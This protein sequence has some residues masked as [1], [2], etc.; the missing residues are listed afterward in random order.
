V[1]LDVARLLGDSLKPART[2]IFVAFDG[3]EWGL[4]GSRRY[5]ATMRHWP[6]A[7]AH[8]MVNL[9]TVGRLGDQRLLVLGSGTATEWPHIARGVGF[10]TG[11]DSTC[12]ADDPGGSDQVVF[13][14]HGVPAVQL[15]TGPHEDYHRSTDTADKLDY[16]GLVKVATWLRETIVYLAGRRES[17]T[18]TLATRGPGGE[19]L[20]ERP[21]TGRRVSLGTMPD[22]AFAGPGVKVASVI[23]GSPAEQA[24]VQANDVIIAVD[25]AALT[26]LKA[27]GAALRGKS[28]GDM[29]LVRVRRGDE[30]LDLQAT[31]IA[32]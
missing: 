30:T 5:A 2:I 16:D 10:T 1:L 18:S 8:S 12:V 11:V 13:H 31:L 32:R 17:L 3:E 26:D 9:D 28:P 19:S 15:F 7:R 25:G 23:A 29:I 4:K 22:F 24:G 20:T 6:I 21:T 14:E 27:Y